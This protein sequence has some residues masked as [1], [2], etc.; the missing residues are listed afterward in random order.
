MPVTHRF[1]SAKSDSADA[2]LVRPSNWN[3]E[4]LGNP[5]P[6]FV[7]APNDASADVKDGA[8]YVCDGTADEVQ[9]Q[10][11]IDALPT[12]GG[13]II[14]AGGRFNIDSAPVTFAPATIAQKI[15]VYGYGALLSVA[16]SIAAVWINQGSTGTARGVHIH[17]LRIDGGDLSSNI[18]V[19][20]EDTNWSGLHD[21][22]I[23]NCATGILMHAN[24]TN[25]FVEGITLEDVI[26][27]DPTTY[28]IEFRRTSGTNS[29]GQHNYRGLFINVGGTGT[30]F[31]LPSGCSIY[32][33]RMDV[34]IWIGTSQ[35]AFD[36]DGDADGA[37]LQWSVE[38]GTGSTGNTA[39]IIGTNATNFDRCDI[40]WYT[41]GTINTEFTVAAGKDLAYHQGRNFKGHTQNT[42]SPLRI[43][44]NADSAAKI[45]L[46]I[47]GT[48]GGRITLGNGSGTNDV[49]LE[50]LGALL[51][52]IGGN[53]IDF[54]EMTEPAAGSTNHGRLYVKDNGSGKSQLC[55]RFPTGAVQ[56]LATEP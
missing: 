25:E 30:G 40:E 44:S 35:V 50:R 38:G 42:T 33:S 51:L 15:D 28:G 19:T 13:V 20:F 43:M 47:N 31:K 9:I 46:G 10:A 1:V 14:L 55:V 56:V 53:A 37:S 54:T 52:G 21:V 2:T 45:T 8:D 49:I 3:D 16:A 29:F 12:R 39:L 18:G 32:R 11:A 23:D 4:H 22:L 26:I 41:T 7:V 5:F 36:C 34:Q 24:D 48:A 17:G 27:R 6:F